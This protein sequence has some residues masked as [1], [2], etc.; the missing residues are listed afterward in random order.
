MSET[1]DPDN[2]GPVGPRRR[3]LPA[4]PPARPRATPARPQYHPTTETDPSR[5]LPPPPPPPGLAPPR[6]SPPVSSETTEIDLSEGLPANLKVPP[7]GQRA[8][9]PRRD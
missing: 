7:P 2:T 6:G 8:G 3:D 5:G 1:Y 4:V 9:D